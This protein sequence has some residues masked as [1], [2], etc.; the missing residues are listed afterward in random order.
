MELESSAFGANGRIPARYAALGVAGGENTSIPYAWHSAP[1]GV[2]SYVL[3]IV[4][5]APVAREWVHW[6][7][8]DIPAKASSIPEG[9]SGTSAMPAGSIEL[10]GTNGSAGYSG[11]RPPQGSGDH[12]Y[13]ATLYALDIPSVGLASGSNLDN[14]QRAIAG[15]VLGQASIT[16]HFER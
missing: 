16:G 3:A 13:E 14:V 5:H 8:V 2:R 7:V 9:A 10:V 12:P 11:P 15:H 1:E 6:V 4:D